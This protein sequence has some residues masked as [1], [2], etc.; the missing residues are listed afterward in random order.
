MSSKKIKELKQ[1]QKKNP[2]K[3][4]LGH[5]PGHNFMGKGTQLTERLFLA[6]DKLFDESEREGEKPYNMP[7][8]LGDIISIQHDLG[9]T[10]ENPINR[11]LADKFMEKQLGEAIDETKSGPARRAM[12]I[13]KLAIGKG[14]A[15]FHYLKI[16]SKIR[17][18]MNKYNIVDELINPTNK[19]ERIK[20]MNI[21]EQSN[22]GNELLNQINEYSRSFGIFQLYQKILF[23]LGI[24]FDDYGKAVIDINKNLNEDEIMRK[25]DF[26]L[27]N[28]VDYAEDVNKEDAIILK[29]LELEKD[30]YLDIPPKEVFDTLQIREIREIEENINISPVNID[31]MSGEILKKTVSPTK[32]QIQDV[33]DDALKTKNKKSGVTDAKVAEKIL[34]FNITPEDFDNIDDLKIFGSASSIALVKNA[35]KILPNF[36]RFTEGQTKE[37]AKARLAHTLIKQISTAKQGGNTQS[38]I[39]NSIVSNSNLFYKDSVSEATEL[40]RQLPVSDVKEARTPTLSEELDQ[41]LENI[42]S[43]ET[44]PLPRSGSITPTPI[45]IEY[46]LLEEDVGEIVNTFKI[47]SEKKELDPKIL[48]RI[49]NVNTRTQE[50]IQKY[51]TRRVESVI[52]EDELDLLKSKL[53]KITKSV[54]Q[55]QNNNE[56]LSPV[57]IEEID[58]II[59]K[60]FNKASAFANS[61]RV[62]FIK[63]LSYV[64]KNLPSPEYLIKIGEKPV[65]TGGDVRQ[66]NFNPLL[67]MSV[68]VNPNLQTRV[69]QPAPT[70]PPPA[71]PSKAGPPPFIP[72]PTPALPV[73]PPPFRP[74]KTIPPFSEFN[75]FRA[76]P[77]GKKKVE[78]EIAPTLNVTETAIPGSGAF[79]PIQPQSKPSDSPSSK[80]ERALADFFLKYGGK[81]FSEIKDLDIEINEIFKLMRN[82]HLN[83]AKRLKGSRLTAEEKDDIE[84]NISDNLEAL[85]TR[86]LTV[87]TDTYDLLKNFAN[88][89]ISIAGAEL[90]EEV[91]EEELEQKYPPYDFEGKQPVEEVP[92]SGGGTVPPVPPPVNPDPLVVQRQL[93]PPPDAWAL[94]E[95]ERKSEY[96][97]GKLGGKIISPDEMI[98]E[99]SKHNIHANRLLQTDFSFNQPYMVKN[100]TLNENIQTQLFLIEDSIDAYYAGVPIHT[101]ELPIKYPAGDIRNRTFGEVPPMEMNS[102]GDYEDDSE[103]VESS[104]DHINLVTPYNDFSRT[105][106]SSNELS[107]E[108]IYD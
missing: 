49:K 75:P 83:M 17:D 9:Y 62:N 95:S 27:S 108:V 12:R 47:P 5:Y 14:M 103:F 82:K 32:E 73:K 69:K 2:E 13:A 81:K 26:F 64:S 30:I 63:Y 52:R 21:L 10:S 41:S 16:D 39:L 105:D 4:L 37:K 42:T 71:I 11:Y 53:Q 84:G 90:G 77:I 36:A 8:D 20:L 56:P 1:L 91:E 25:Y 23:D 85:V 79:T 72:R 102:L 88:G 68:L 38:A 33:V 99:I 80:F 28:L 45:E 51:S 48:E 87:G 18:L 93:V 24:A 15:N 46:D 92:P 31:N 59:S 34:K 78:V 66:L 86:D 54:A 50:L 55:L 43:G 6:Y 58:N 61:D 7:V 19:E 40:L 98:L 65:S 94:S 29:K 100:Q 89:G 104:N 35:N 22:E 97:Q 76:Q 107:S 70:R 96:S 101:D 57:E 106:L 74:T 44:S 3:E 60:E 67:E